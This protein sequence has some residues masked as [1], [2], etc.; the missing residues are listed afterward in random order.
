M[1][2]YDATRFDPPAPLALVTLRN[3]ETGATQSDVPML[4][5]SGADVTLIPQSV[6]S[7]LGIATIPGTRYELAGLAGGTS[8]AS[9]IRAELVF[10]RRNFRGQFLLAEQPWGILGRNVLNEIALLLDGP[11][12]VWEEYI[13]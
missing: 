10:S 9:A 7:Q 13:R 4:I 12:L 1:P 11:Q 6:A 8:L 5:D 3:L 2:A